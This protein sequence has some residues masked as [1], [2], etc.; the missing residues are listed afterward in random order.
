MFRNGLAKLLAALAARPRPNLRIHPDDAVPLLDWLPAAGL[1]GIDLLYPDPWPKR[2]QWKRRFVSPANLDRFARALKPGAPFRFA[3]DVGSY[4]EWTRQHVAAHAAFSDATAEH[5]GPLAPF[6][7]WP[8]TR[9]E[10]KALREGRPPAY[11]TFR[12][13]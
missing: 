3:S 13:R 8:G 1:A 6:P 10:A 9:Y 7:G 2:K 12:R 5:G 4:V 11:L